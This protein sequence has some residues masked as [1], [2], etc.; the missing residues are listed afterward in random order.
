MR[1]T[2]EPTRY[3]HALGV[4]R[5]APAVAHVDGTLET[6][7][8]HTVA[9]Q[10]TCWQLLHDLDGGLD[11]DLGLVLRF[12]LIH[13]LPEALTGDEDT[14]G[15]SDRALTA[16]AQRDAAALEQTGRDLPFLAHRQ[17]QYE[18]QSSAE[19]VFVRCVDKMLPKIN[20]VIAGRRLTTQDEVNW[21]YAQMDRETSPLVGCR[22]YEPLRQVWLDL[23]DAI[24]PA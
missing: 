14:F 1:S 17:V 13:D 19:A 7:S 24:R 16:K 21:C 20:R 18:R 2:F 4:T 9:L 12:A 22:I 3:A 11:L 15:A 6:V 8:T 10:L 5:R 23:L